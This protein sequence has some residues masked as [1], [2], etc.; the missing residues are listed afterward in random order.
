VPAYGKASSR[1][2]RPQDIINSP[3]GKH[4][5]KIKEGSSGTGLAISYL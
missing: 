5:E 1:Q 3:A 2:A 4:S